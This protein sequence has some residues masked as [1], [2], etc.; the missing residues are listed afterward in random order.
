MQQARRTQ[1]HA[2]PPI[3]LRQPGR[4]DYLTAWRDM[5]TFTDIREPDTPDELWLM[6]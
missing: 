3:R 5:Q 6:A 4:T 1:T 2:Y